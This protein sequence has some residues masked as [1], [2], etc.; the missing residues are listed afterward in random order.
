VDWDNKSDAFHNEWQTGND[1][2]KTVRVKVA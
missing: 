2:T 1:T